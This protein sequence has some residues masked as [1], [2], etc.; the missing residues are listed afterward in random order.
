[1]RK[2]KSPPGGGGQRNS[3][4]GV[5]AG[6]KLASKPKEGQAA[7]SGKEARPR[8]GV[9]KFRG[10]KAKDRRRTFNE[11]EAL[12]VLGGNKEAN[13][14][15]TRGTCEKGRGKAE[16]KKVCIRKVGPSLYE[17]NGVNNI[18]RPARLTNWGP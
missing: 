17:N 12:S 3:A 13:R 14:E 11:K 10:G 16:K 1:L 18:G 5:G 4:F 7:I 15:T 8:D 2:G 9:I 6:Q